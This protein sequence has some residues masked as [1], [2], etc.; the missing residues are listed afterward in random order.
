MK[1]LCFITISPFSE[2]D[3]KRYAIAE[4]KDL[5]CDVLILDCTPF[6]DNLF[7]NYIS[8]N[9]LCFKNENIIRCYSLIQ[10][11][12]Y[13]LQFNPNWTI[14]FISYER[15]IYFYSLLIRIVVKL[16]SKIIYYRTGGFPDAT[17]E[18]IYKDK[19]FIFL[20]K[21]KFLL[22]RFIKLPWQIMGPDKW[23]L[24]GYSEFIKVKDKKKIILG[25]NLDYD[26]FLKII[27]NPILKNHSLGNILFL[28][29]DFPCHSDFFREGI[30]SEL[31]EIEYFSEMSLCLKKLEEIFNLK[32]IVKIHPRANFKKS[33]KLYTVNVV[34]KDTA[35]LV[36]ESE[37]VIAHCSTSIQLAVLFYKPIILIIPNKLP[38]KSY[39]FK[40]IKNFKNELGV[41]SIRSKDIG[42]I[43]V[44]PKVDYKK[45]DQY[46]EKFIKMN[47]S[48]NNFSWEIIVKNL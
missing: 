33:S 31:N 34:N 41:E 47:S 32:P 13:F 40:N 10:F 19:R 4:I 12:R 20:R 24:G 18:Q 25:H 15:K 30:K 44:M 27:R 37:L 28:D 7:E 36:Y 8:G 42:K 39:Y 26:N 38:N 14:D 45:Y 35:R 3:Y 16:T 22:G 17:N 2:R 23:I 21:I 43:K 1:R 29:E 5:G 6:L 48:E 11:L 46:K 9:D